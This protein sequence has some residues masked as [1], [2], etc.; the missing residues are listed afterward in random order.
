MGRKNQGGLLATQ[1]VLAVYVPVFVGAS[2]CSGNDGSAYAL[3]SFLQ[4]YACSEL[5]Q[6][7]RHFKYH[8]LSVMPI[9]NRLLKAYKALTINYL[10][11]NTTSGPD[12]TGF[13]ASQLTAD[14]LRGSSVVAAP[15]L[16]IARSF[17]MLSI[18]VEGPDGQ[19][20][21]GHPIEQL[22][23]KGRLLG[24]IADNYFRFGNVYLF[25]E[26]DGSRGITALEYRDGVRMRPVW[27]AS[28]TPETYYYWYPPG[29]TQRQVTVLEEELLHIRN[30]ISPNNPVLGCSPLDGVLQEIAVDLEAAGILQVS[31]AKHG[32]AWTGCQPGCFRRGTWRS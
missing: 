8:T 27:T 4:L 28:A 9:L 23:S 7:L 6:N 18:H 3:G 17:G 16:W 15:L 11:A 19:R 1:N 21:E 25:L 20:I 5:V 13:M 10:P 30:G 29:P 22:L 31:P 14:D 26:R 32:R 24:A 12:D 2:V